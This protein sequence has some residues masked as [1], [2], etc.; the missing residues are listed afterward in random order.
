MTKDKDQLKSIKV[1]KFNNIKEGWYEFVLKFRVIADSRGHE[2]IIE[3][4]ETPPDI[5]EKMEITEKAMKK[6]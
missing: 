5:K 3:G 2:D 1:Y 4:T 6:S